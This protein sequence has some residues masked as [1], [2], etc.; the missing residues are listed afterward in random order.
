MSRPI[1]IYSTPRKCSVCQKPA[2]LWVLTAKDVL[3][4]PDKS[5]VQPRCVDHEETR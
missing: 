1:S 5:S 3:G 4:A 2:T